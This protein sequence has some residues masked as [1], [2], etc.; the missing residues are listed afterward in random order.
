MVFIAVLCIEFH[1]NFV[2]GSDMS[3]FTQNNEFLRDVMLCYSVIPDLD[4][5]DEGSVFGRIVLDVLKDCAAFVFWVIDRAND[6][7]CHFRRLLISSSG[8]EGAS[9]SH[10]S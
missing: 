3:R 9:I 8:A 7:A 10:Y 5:E 2:F 4:R 1:K 6:A